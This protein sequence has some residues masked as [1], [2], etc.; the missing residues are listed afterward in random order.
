[1]PNPPKNI[2]NARA[3]ENGANR[4]CARAA[5]DAERR[6]RK[7]KCENGKAKRE[8][9]WTLR[10]GRRRR[11]PP[12]LAAS[13]PKRDV[14]PPPPPPARAWYRLPPKMGPIHPPN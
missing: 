2:N 1:M 13:R 10:R 11:P 7:T 5:A 9:K 6:K 12:A 14:C 3:R 4:E 8:T